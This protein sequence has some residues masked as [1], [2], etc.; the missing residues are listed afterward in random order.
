MKAVLFR[1][2]KVG[3][4]VSLKYP[5]NGTKNILKSYSGE[6]VEKAQGM[7]TLQSGKN[8]R[9]FIDNKI[10]GKITVS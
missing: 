8:F 9:R 4:S 3:D 2:V 5:K 1:A 6:V 10:S 7:L